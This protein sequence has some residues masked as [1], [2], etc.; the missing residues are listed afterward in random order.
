MRLKISS[1]EVVRDCRSE[2][3]QQTA[4]PVTIFRQLRSI[5]KGLN[6]E[7]GVAVGCQLYK[8]GI[9]LNG[10][11]IGSR[12][13]IVAKKVGALPIEMEWEWVLE[14]TGPWHRGQSSGGEGKGNERGG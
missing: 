2:V 10:G 9:F 1:A 11:V 13:G 7:E 8:R 12:V 5:G 4:Q 3:G 14:S 6:F